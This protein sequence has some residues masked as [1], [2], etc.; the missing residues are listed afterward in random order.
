[1]DREARHAAVPGVTK[2]QIQLS[3]WTD[4]WASFHVFNGLLYVLFGKI[5]IDVFWLFYNKI[6][7]IFY[8]VL[9]IIYYILYNMYIMYILHI[10]PLS[11]IPLENIFS[12]TVGCLFFFVDGFLC[13]TADFRLNWVPLVYFCVVSFAWGDRSKI[14]C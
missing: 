12:H 13:C 9:C 5:F 3:Y 4:D 6:G 7:F 14:Y 1:M 8:I 2:S 10:N 11:V